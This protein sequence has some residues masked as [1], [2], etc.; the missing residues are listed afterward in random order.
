MI[1]KGPVGM[2]GGCGYMWHGFV[3]P[4]VLLWDKFNAMFEAVASLW[5]CK[6]VQGGLGV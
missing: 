2:C 3:V 4:A 6:A 5:D 1:R